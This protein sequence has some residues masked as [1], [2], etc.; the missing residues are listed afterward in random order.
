M[1]APFV[2]SA[3]RLSVGDLFDVEIAAEL[4]ADFVDRFIGGIKL[5]A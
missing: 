1:S 3:L 5:R 2:V 4:F